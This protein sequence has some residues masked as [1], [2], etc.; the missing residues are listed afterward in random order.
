MTWFSSASF[1]PSAFVL[2]YP[3]AYIDNWFR[4]QERIERVEKNYRKEGWRRPL[5]ST[6]QLTFEAAVKTGAHETAI[7]AALDL[8]SPGTIFFGLEMHHPS[9]TEFSCLSRF[10]HLGRAKI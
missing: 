9:S 6:I 7:R 3:P 10:P 8:L 2:Y 4:F 1:F 5:D